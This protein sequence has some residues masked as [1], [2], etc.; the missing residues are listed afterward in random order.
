MEKI[1]SEW[2]EIRDSKIHNKGVF[3]VKDIPKNTKIIE[4][5]GERVD[6]KDWIK[7]KWS[8]SRF[9]F[10]ENFKKENF[11]VYFAW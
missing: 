11:L 5:V 9:Y 6:K 4:Y 3:T 1:K 2:I 7:F 8:C 10:L